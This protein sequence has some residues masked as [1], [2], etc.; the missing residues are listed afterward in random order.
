MIDLCRGP[1]V[2]HTG[3][4][5]ALKIHKVSSSFLRQVAC[6]VLSYHWTRFGQQCGTADYYV[7]LQQCS[8]SVGPAT[9][10]SPGIRWTRETHVILF[11]VSG[12]ARIRLP[13]GRGRRTW[14]PSRGST[15][16]P[17][18]TP[19]CSKTGRS[20]RRR[21]RTEITANWAGYEERR[22]FG[23]Q[24]HYRTGFALGRKVICSMC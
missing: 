8:D 16:S 23:L 10:H 2:R 24:S 4:I 15:E 7:T 5:K 9:F 21:P 14:K 20:F 19:R 3:K 18:P 11:V 13:T 1:H 22:G 17:S 12:S 6:C